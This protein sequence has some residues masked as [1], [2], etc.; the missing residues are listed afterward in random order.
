MGMLC[1]DGHI[2]SRSGAE[3]TGKWRIGFCEGDHKVIA[4]YVHLTKV[5][6]NLTPTVRKRGNWWDAYYCSRVAYEWFTSVGQ[7]PNGKKLGKLLIP[8][9][10][11]ESQD[12][13]CGFT[14]GLFTVE[15]SVKTGKYVKITLEMLEPT[16]VK[17]VFGVLQSNGISAHL[18]CYAK[19]AKTMYGTYIYGAADAQSFLSRFGLIEKKHWKLTNLLSSLEKAASAR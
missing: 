10:V 4:Y 16:L 13:L 15:G 1:G 11:R 17:Q 8:K 19:Q 18:Y 6:F 3:R 2:V 9:A 5:L 7:H 12:A 14:C